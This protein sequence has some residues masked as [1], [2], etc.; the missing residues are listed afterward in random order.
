[1][2]MPVISPYSTQGK[3]PLQSSWFSCVGIAVMTFISIQFIPS[4]AVEPTFYFFFRFEKK[5][6]PIKRFAADQDVLQYRIM[7]TDGKYKSSGEH[8]DGASV[9]IPRVSLPALTLSQCI[10][11]SNLGSSIH[12]IPHFMY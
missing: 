11:H 12:E 1:M 4:L 8:R 10:L 2:L 3:R 5:K 9:C 7:E 6:Q